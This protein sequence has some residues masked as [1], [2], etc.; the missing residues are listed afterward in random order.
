MRKAKARTP[1]HQ[2]RARATTPRAAPAQAMQAGGLEYPRSSSRVEKLSAARPARQCVNERQRGRGLFET[3]GAGGWL[4]TVLH[5]HLQRLRLLRE[6]QALR[7]RE[8]S[9]PL[10]PIKRLA[11]REEVHSAR[12]ER[13][14]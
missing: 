6:D 10:A 12:A 9:T 5:S 7:P 2:N 14:K 1:K 4:A 11:E 8:M 13:Q 3:R